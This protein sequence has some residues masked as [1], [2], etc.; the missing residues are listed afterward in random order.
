MLKRT[1]S[2]A[3]FVA[4]IAGF[5]CLKE[6]VD[7]RLLSI[8]IYFCSMIGT[9]ELAR[10]LKDKI[11][12]KSMW[13]SVVYGILFV[14][15]YAVTEFFIAKGVGIYISLILALLCMLINVVFCFIEKRGV[16]DLLVKSL[17][18]VYPSFLFLSMLIVSTMT[19][20]KSLIGLLLIFAIS[21]LTDTL[22]YLVGMIYNKIRKGKAKK[23]CPRLSPKKTWAGAI[24]GT[25][26]G[27]LGSILVFFIFKNKC[28]SLSLPLPL[29]ILVVVGFVGAILTQI[30]DLFESGIKRKVGIKDMG[31]IMPGH[32]GILDRFDGMLFTSVLVCIFLLII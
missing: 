12:K 11:G 20:A 24:G 21:P 22:A 29:L 31:K 16:K 13:L 10:A 4:V 23:L 14:P 30:G 26:G 32:G 18:M 19:G 1:I 3:C 7:S 9:M 6:F 2:G 17:P 25:I 8:L 15:S 5:L 27:V 28:L